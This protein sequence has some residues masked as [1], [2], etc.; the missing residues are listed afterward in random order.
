MLPA[1]FCDDVS[2][3][4]GGLLLGRLTLPDLANGGTLGS[5]FSMESFRRM[6]LCRNAKQLQSVCILL[7]RQFS[8]T[9]IRVA[10]NSSSMQAKRSVFHGLT[11]RLSEDSAGILRL[12]NAGTAFEASQKPAPN[13]ASNAIPQHWD[14]V[15]SQFKVGFNKTSNTILNTGTVL[16]VGF[17]SQQLPKELQ[18][19]SPAR[20][21]RPTIREP[22][23]A[24]TVHRSLETRWKLESLRQLPTGPCHRLRSGNQTHKV[25]GC[26]RRPFGEGGFEAFEAFEG[27]GSKGGG[28]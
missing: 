23:S 13:K 28:E 24:S 16:E 21:V 15:W 27:E 7:A 12:P 9:N 10:C 14:G 3:G 4:N 6:E 17:N 8:L 19:L 26:I 20:A 1:T 5:S 22:L 11:D 18:Q 2:D 25:W